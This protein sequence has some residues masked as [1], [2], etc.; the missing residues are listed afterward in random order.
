MAEAN[1]VISPRIGLPQLPVMEWRD[2]DDRPDDGLHWKT[3]GLVRWAAGRTFV[4][5][6]DEIT[7]VDRRWI[8][9]QHKGRALPHRVDPRLGLT[10]RDFQ[11]IRRWLAVEP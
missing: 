2:S 9:E 6:D 1:E 5:V 8:A 11:T 3:S 7:G 10:D 4:W